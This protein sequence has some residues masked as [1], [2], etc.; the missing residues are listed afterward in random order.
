VRL[1]IRIRMTA[2]YIALTALV[3]VAIGAF[4]VIALRRDLTVAVDRSQKLAVSRVAKDFR[5]EGPH[6]LADSSQTVLGGDRVAAQVT[7][8]RGRVIASYGDPV[9]R[10]PMVA[11]VPE[12]ATVTLQGRQ[13]RVA[14][15]RVLRR[16]RPYVVVAGQSLVLVDRSVHRVMVLLLLAGPAALVLIAGGGWLVARRALQPVRR[17]TDTAERI[18]VERLDGRV[19]VPATADEV[20]ALARTFNRMLDRIQRGV[21]EQHRLIA[22]TSH[23]L[24]TPLAAMRAELDV[25]LRTDELTPAAREVLESTREEV[26]GMSRTVDDLLLLAGADE[27]RME[28][29]AEPLDLGELAADVVRALTP[30]AGGTDVAVELNGGPA[31]VLGDRE[32]LRHAIRNL[33]E[34]G[35]KFTPPGGRVDVTSWTADGEAGL[36]VADDGPGIAP[37]LRER[38]FDRFFRVDPSRTRATGGSGLGL[39]IARE[40]I[41]A[42]GG[43]VHV[44]DGSRFVIELPAARVSQRDKTVTSA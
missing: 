3:I 40:V 19:A 22:D 33:I 5:A 20:G 31:P 14:A 37:E 39:A 13:F 27:G 1:P 36:T 42:H 35:L 30:I 25:S 16:G 6:E 34:N 41:A 21:E 2:W 24:R 18:G 26:D 7:D 12:V 38:V 23:E 9:S 11:G 43:S 44:A 32:S 15:R 29:L 4:V 8:A 17:V 10:A 28:L